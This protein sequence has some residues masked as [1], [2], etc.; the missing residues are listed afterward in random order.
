MSISKE[1]QARSG[2]RCEMCGASNDLAAYEVP[3]S[4]SSGLD[5][6]IVVCK[7]CQS[8][9]EDSTTVDPNH[10]R[11]LNESMWSEVP[12]VQVMAWRMLHRLRHEGWP[13]DLIDMLYLEEDTL[14]WARAAG[15]DSTEE[16]IQHTD[17]NGNLLKAGDTVVLIQDLKVKG[18]NFTAK[19]GTA[20]VLIS[21]DHDNAEHIEGKVDG[22]HIVILTKY[23][24]KVK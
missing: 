2:D 3:D 7:I 4:P 8:Q 24:K 10:W 12:A 19:R 22:Q 15:Y 23:V 14:Q 18:A 11:C 21:L 5:A 20:V 9:M 16:A 13:N 6:S 17:S 1:L